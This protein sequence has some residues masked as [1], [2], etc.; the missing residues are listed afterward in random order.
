MWLADARIKFQNLRPSN[1]LRT[2]YYD[3]DHNTIVFQISKNTSDCLTLETQTETPRYNYKKTHWK[4]FQH[5]LEQNCDLK[6]YNNVNLTDS[7]IDSFIDEIEKHIQIALQE[8]VPT[9]KE[10]DS[11]EPYV[12]YK[13]KKLRDKSYILSKLNNLKY[14]YSYDKREDIEFLKYLLYKIKSQLK[15][16]FANSINQYWTNKIKNIFKKDSASMLP[17]INQIFRP[18]EQNSIPPHKL[19]PE[20]ASLIQ[21]AGIEI[22]N[23]NKDT[24]GNFIIYKTTK[25]L[26]ILGTHFS[27]THTQKDQ[28]CREQLNKLSSP[29]QTN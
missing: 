8:S 26:N 1:T 23:S 9:L 25:K 29:K 5:L 14:N 7:Q 22:H 12:N 20:K 4:K 10:K 6:I 13:I 17:H 16:E 11:C 21:E 28:M 15:Q 18:K 3:S 19:P 2:L 24:E 27:K